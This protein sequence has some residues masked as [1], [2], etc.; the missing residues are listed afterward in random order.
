MCFAWPRISHLTGSMRIGDDVVF[1]QVLIG[2]P[3]GARLEIGSRCSFN[4]F[5]ILWASQSIRIG[6]DVMVA[7]SV[8]IRDSNHST[9]RHDIPMRLQGFETS[10]IEIGSD[11]WICR[12]TA[13]LMGS[14]VGGG[15]VIGANSVV[16]GEI[17]PYSVA[18]GAPA[19][20]VRDR[21]DTN[22]D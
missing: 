18:V 17:G 14:K 8:T 6:D 20:V 22:F 2:V 5:T 1:G 13:I 12:G 21:R 15:C 3:P 9:R 10:P 4:D 11:V 7:E 16:K 19:R